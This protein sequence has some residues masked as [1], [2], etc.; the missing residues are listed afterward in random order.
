MMTNSDIEKQYIYI[1]VYIYIGI[2]MIVMIYWLI[3]YAIEI[4][5]YRISLSC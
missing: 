3:L 1:Y 5:Y 4:Y 2:D